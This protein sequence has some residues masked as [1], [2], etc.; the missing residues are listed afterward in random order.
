MNSPW[1]ARTDNFEI[2]IINN[3]PHRQ[4]F[5]HNNL[6]LNYS[7][8][9]KM[10][11]KFAAVILDQAKILKQED[12]ANFFGVHFNTIINWKNR[13][14][15]E[16]PGSLVQ[17]DF[18]KPPEKA[19]QELI[20]FIKKVWQEQ[21]PK[22]FKDINSL[23]NNKFG[24]T[25]S[26]STFSRIRNNHK[27][28]NDPR[29][30]EQKSL[31]DF[32]EDSGS[33][34]CSFQ[35]NV[36]DNIDKNYSFETQKEQ[37]I[38]KNNKD[39]V[40][41]TAEIIN[42]EEQKLTKSNLSAEQKK[43]I[44]EKPIIDLTENEEEQSFQLK[45]GESVKSRYGA[46]LLYSNLI[47]SL[48]KPIF[49]YVQT[50]MD[51]FH[52]AYKQ[53]NIRHLLTT[54]IF[55]FL[56]NIH[57]PERTKSIDRK[58]FGV[59]IGR[60]K[61]FCCKTL[62]SSL[63]YLTEGE[64]PIYLPQKL[65][66]QYVRNGY[67]ELGVIYFD[68]HFIPYYGKL[69]VGKGYFPQKRLAVPG[70]YQYWANS[71]N[72]RPIFF[73]LKQSF[74]HFTQVIPQMVQQALDL[75]KELNISDRPLIVVFDRG[76][77]SAEVFKELDQM[78]VGW[79]SWKKYSKEYKENM[80]TEKVTITAKKGKGKEY[81]MFKTE[82]SITDYR[83]DVETIVILD[84]KTGKQASLINNL[85]RI[86]KEDYTPQ[87]AVNNLKNRWSQEN[88]FKQ[89]K[90][91]VDLDHQMG[92]NITGCG[93]DQY[94]VPNPEYKELE[95]KITKLE[96]KFKKA[97]QKRREMCE[98]Y[99]DL[100]RKKPFKEY[101]QQKDN[102]KIRTRYRNLRKELK[103]TRKKSREVPP[104]IPFNQLDDDDKQVMDFERNIVITAI[105]AAVFNIRSRMTELAAECFN[106]HRELSKFLE[107][108]MNS[109]TTITRDKGTYIIEL[110]LN[111]P[112]RYC[113]SAELLIGKINKENPRSLD[114]A[115]MALSFKLKES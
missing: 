14:Y 94:I 40:N 69:N 70:H 50:N 32:F 54:L 114:G 97:K 19:T 31:F 77:Y 35:E 82:S 21:G 80:F 4:L 8:D 46:V 48:F 108:L 56:L 29:H 99:P 60:K 30:P 111:A 79:I 115:N 39:K 22:T 76:G 10:F 84:E 3:P 42:Y 44:K 9:S 92:Y 43:E 112:P 15:S 27:L 1:E 61:G 73:Y 55:M 25:I 6:L 5:V 59:L 52:S 33:D 7:C 28:P 49:R 88:F 87:K 12:L 64:L 13:V 85:D 41:T 86:L 89:A 58:S 37:K 78:G 90:D 63:N 74:Q 83:E 110:D 103:E 104:G 16:G 101:L 23:I 24:Y 67:V 72:G 38:E 75:R 91:Y 17:K 65:T 105:K 45:N 47:H 96:K 51:K 34:V 62:R 106:D 107:S 100:K 81:K 98:R 113:K 57:N 66:K 68:G 20:D 109:E 53:F 71:K 93:D 2:V 95:E 11:D 26:Q 18:G 102:T 36:T